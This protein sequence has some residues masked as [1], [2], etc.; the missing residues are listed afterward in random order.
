MQSA[1]VPVAHSPPK[2]TR[3]RRLRSPFQSPFLSPDSSPS[4]PNLNPDS[5]PSTPI[6]TQK[7]NPRPSSQPNSTLPLKTASKSPYFHLKAEFTAT[8]HQL[9]H[10]SPHKITSTAETR[11]K[12]VQPAINP[13]S[14][15]PLPPKKEPLPSQKLLILTHFYSIPKLPYLHFLNLINQSSAYS[16]PLSGCIPA[17]AASIVTGFGII[18]SSPGT[19]FA[20]V[21]Q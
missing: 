7:R 20:G 1:L 5:A 8:K 10:S 13:P 9:F 3:S 15:K 12:S 17:S 2:R 6:T 14:T 19:Q 11:P 21:A 18:T 4:T 16:S